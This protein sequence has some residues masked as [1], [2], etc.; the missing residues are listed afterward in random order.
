MTVTPPRPSPWSEEV[1]GLI[2][3][4]ARLQFFAAVFFVFAPLALLWELGSGARQS[5]AQ[6]LPWVLFSG[7]TAVGWALAFLRNT[8]FLFVVIPVSFALP[9]LV[10]NDYWARTFTPH[11]LLVIIASIACIAI[12]YAF[13]IRFIMHQGA[14]RVRLQ[15]EINLARD[16]HT[17]L[18]PPLARRTPCV[19][20]HGASIPTTE[21]GGDLLDVV[22]R[23]DRTGIFVADVSGHGVPAGV[24]MAMLKSAVRMHARTENDLTTLVR[25][26]NELLLDLDRPTMFATF[27]ALQFGEPGEVEVALAGHP[28]ILVWRQATGEIEPLEN[29][30]PPLGIVPGCGFASRRARARSGDVFVLLTDGLTEVVDA[31]NE[32]FGGERIAARL[33]DLA[34][35]PLAEL[36]DGILQAVR[37]HG[38]QVDDQT[39]VVARVL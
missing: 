14:S 6:I 9:M 37:A 36:H 17:S 34:S 33:R 31:A 22:E 28:P 10:G 32:E 24:L 19:E 18:V 3:W 27:A 16:I 13:F 38:P 12:G 4:G 11:H 25:H 23:G 20:I 35:R 7:A 29:D 8:R 2:P 26:L 21:V 5:W 15:T 1:F 39:L 30:H